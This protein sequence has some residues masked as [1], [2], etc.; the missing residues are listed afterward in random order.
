MSGVEGSKSSLTVLE[1]CAGGG[2]MALGLE[3]AGIE[4]RALIEIDPH[5]CATLRRNRPYWNV[6]QADMRRFDASYWRG[7]DLVSAGL[8]CPPFSIA[9][10]Q[11]GAEDDRDMFPPMLQIVRATRPRAVLI[12]N[13][14]GILINRFASFRA[15]IDAELNKDGFDT[16]WMGFNA[17]DF[18]VPQNRF[19]APKMAGPDAQAGAHSWRG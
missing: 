9:D 19:R 4:P 17:A 3:E 6:V 2:G 7:A 14:R 13:V 12:E 5:A 10:K 16:H 1:L 18:G 15:W 11:L 8:P